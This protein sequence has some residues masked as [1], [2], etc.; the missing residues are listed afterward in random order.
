MDY[1]GNPMGMVADG[2]G[3][4][5]VSD[6]VP[7]GYAPVLTAYVD[8]ADWTLPAWMTADLIIDAEMNSPLDC[9]ARCLA[10]AECDF[11]SYEFERDV[12]GKGS[13]N[14][15]LLVLH[16]SDLTDCL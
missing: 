16:G 4:G 11:F 10:S 14:M 7:C 15:P 6:G 13:H 3:A 1:G 9:Q 2:K 12:S 8:S 5:M